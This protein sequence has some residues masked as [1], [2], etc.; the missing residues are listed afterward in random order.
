MR[1]LGKGSAHLRS[2]AKFLTFQLPGI[3]QVS[4]QSSSSGH[5]KRIT[6]F[7]RE[8]CVV[9]QKDTTTPTPVNSSQRTGEVSSL[10]A[11]LAPCQSL[12][13]EP[14]TQFAWPQSG[15]RAL[16]SL[17]QRESSVV[18]FPNPSQNLSGPPP[19]TPP[20]PCLS[21]ATSAHDINWSN[22]ARTCPFLNRHVTSS[23]ACSRTTNATRSAGPR[24]PEKHGE[25]WARY[26]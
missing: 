9:T 18:P 24:R 2:Q 19:P 22:D 20:H 7:V 10:R 6:L 13:H 11:I 25:T 15:P 14:R 4:S 12:S 8:V 5:A 16:R 1:N 17:F 23:V 26:P 21:C 3:S